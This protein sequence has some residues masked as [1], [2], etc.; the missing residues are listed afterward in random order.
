MRELLEEGKRGIFFALTLRF[1]GLFSALLKTERAYKLTPLD[2]SMHSENAFK[3]Y[4]L[5][6]KKFMNKLLQIFFCIALGHCLENN[7]IFSV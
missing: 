7:T 4:I 2:D 6:W 1:L 3:S 5:T